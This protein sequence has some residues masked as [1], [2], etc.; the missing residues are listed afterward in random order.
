MLPDRNEALQPCRP[1]SVEV[2]VL[3]GRDEFTDA[4]SNAWRPV[5]VT[6]FDVRGPRAFG[7]GRGLSDKLSILDPELVHV[8][9]LWQYASLAALRWH[10]KTAKPYMVSPHGMLDP[11]A[12]AHSGWR[13]RLAWTAYEGRHLRSSQ[14]IRALCEAEAT[15][16]RATGLMNPICI[17]PN[18]IDLPDPE[19]GQRPVGRESAGVRS[20]KGTGPDGDGLIGWLAGRKVL[21]YLGRI[22]PKKGLSNLV[23]TWTRMRP[24]EEWVL[25][26]AGWDQGGHEAELKRLA[27]ARAWGGSIVFIGPQHGAEKRQW[28]ERCD[29]FILPSYSEGLPMALLEA[30]SFG[31]PVLATAECN[32]AEGFSAGAAIRIGTTIDEIENGLRVLFGAKNSTLEEMGARGRELVKRRFAWKGVV[33]QLRGVYRWMLGEG[34]RPNC[35]FK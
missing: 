10:G 4:D 27:G 20:A 34:A 12:M 7:Y 16:I 11:W 26:I 22:H 15:A 3:G 28:F 25:V 17:I 21:L 24:P 13:K 2:N 29:A 9:G 14:C 30:W 8:H 5:V 32:L 23:R 1:E 19:N 31:K 18:G 33:S 35:V 6:A